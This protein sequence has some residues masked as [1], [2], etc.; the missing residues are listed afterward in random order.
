[1]V[2]WDALP[3]YR[4]QVA[5]ALAAREPSPDAI[6]GLAD[7]VNVAR[8]HG[9]SK[10]AK[11]H[12]EENREL[13]LWALG[14]YDKIPDEYKRNREKGHPSL[15][16]GGYTGAELIKKF[17]AGSFAFEVAGQEYATSGLRYDWE[18]TARMLRVVARYLDDTTRKESAAA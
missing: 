3:L 10:E 6:Y 9:A 4:E 7:L 8:E 13:L 15:V 12:V 5:A 18:N 16:Q 14:L 1:M 11:D 2:I 17:G